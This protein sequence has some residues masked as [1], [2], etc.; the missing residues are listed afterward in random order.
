MAMYRKCWNKVRERV[1]ERDLACV[2]SMLA[3]G[4]EDDYKFIAEFELFLMDIDTLEYSIEKGNEDDIVK[5]YEQ[6]KTDLQ[7]GLS[8]TC[9]SK[10]PEAEACAIA[11]AWL[12]ILQNA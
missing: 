7:L 5:A 2:S 4:D 9:S 10:L 12:S 8:E 6:F 3:L 1:L 11:L